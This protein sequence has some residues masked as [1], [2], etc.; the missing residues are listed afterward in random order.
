MITSLIRVTITCKAILWVKS[1]H[2]GL[3]MPPKRRSG[4]SGKSTKHLP[5]TRTRAS[6]DTR[7]SGW[8]VRPGTELTE[9]TRQH[10]LWEAKHGVN[11]DG[12]PLA[13][14]SISQ[15]DGKT[16]VSNHGTHDGGGIATSA[17]SS[18]EKPCS[19]EKPLASTSDACSSGNRDVTG[20]RLKLEN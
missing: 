5:G 16:E 8:R 9:R 13:Q 3:L 15:V 18:S 1:R 2:I 10:R 7:Q 11:R 4:R 19:K 17:V 20:K 6:G 14:H 12:E